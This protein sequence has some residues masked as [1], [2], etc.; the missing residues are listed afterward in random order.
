MREFNDTKQNTTNKQNDNTKVF[1][2]GTW[3]ESTW[4]EELI[5]L[6]KVDYFNPIVKNWTPD[7]Q[8]E[9]KR[10]KSQECNVHL[11]VI[12][13]EMTGVFSIAEVIDSAHEFGIETVF[14]VITYGFDEEQLK[15]LDAVGKMV[16]E[17][18]GTY[19]V[20]MMKNILIPLAEFLNDAFLNDA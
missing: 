13:S 1:L 11:Y 16:R 17:H 18:Q 7:C 10:Q 2:G 12:T 20:A 9:E 8:K 14:C 19:I 3:N 6:L 5:P 4:R 15:S